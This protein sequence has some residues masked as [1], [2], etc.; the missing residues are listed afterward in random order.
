MGLRAS[1]R[2]LVVAPF[3]HCFG[4]KAG[5]LAAWMVGAT[6]LP[7]AVFDVDAV[8]ERVVADRITVLPGPPAL[9]QSILAHPGRRGRDLS[10]LRL[11]VTGAAS[12]PVVLIERMRDELG[13]GTVLTGYGLT[14]ACGL[15][16]LCRQGDDALTVATTS[17]RAV[18]GVEVRV[19]GAAGGALPAGEP[20]EVVLR[21][22][23]VMLGFLDDPTDG[24]I[25][26]DGW[27]H[28][29]DVGVM[30]AAGN[31]R[32][33]DRI[34]DMFIV[35]GFNA[36]PAEIEAELC[37][38]PGVAEVAVIGVP[39]ARLGEVGMAFVVPLVS[40]ELDPAALH[41]WCRE[42]MANF[43]VPRA[44]SIVASLPRNA[45]GKVTKGDLRAQAAAAGSAGWR[46]T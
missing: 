18:P 41:R 8:L 12:I 19:V 33:T 44:F 26:A 22:Y 39:D 24:V 40:T 21:G 9:Y 7:H 2:Y 37:R 35:G 46:A 23:N 38:C 32:I 1:D 16:T 10:A 14:E 25:D 5:L 20:G 27:L 3:F 17:G 34:K 4:Y 43:K 30:D 11:A 13:I 29:G 42:H 15:A 28:T 45:S 31:L 36:Y 6:V